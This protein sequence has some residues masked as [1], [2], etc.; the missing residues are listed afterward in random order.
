M[1]EM[2]EKETLMTIMIIMM[3]QFKPKT[4]STISGRSGSV[5]K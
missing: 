3:I 4:N 2:S 5:H 1:S